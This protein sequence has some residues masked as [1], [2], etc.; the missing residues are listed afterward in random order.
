MTNIFKFLYESLYV[1]YVYYKFLFNLY[2][3]E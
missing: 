2:H 3:A 1:L